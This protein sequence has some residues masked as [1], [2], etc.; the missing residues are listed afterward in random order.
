MQI[1]I[2]GGAAVDRGSRST[3]SSPTSAHAAD[4]IRAS[5]WLPQ[6]FGLDRLDDARGGR[7]GGPGHRA[8]HR[9]GPDLPA[10]PDDARGSRPARRPGALPTLG[11]SLG[12]GGDRDHV[13]WFAKPG[14][15]HP[16]VPL[17]PHAPAPG[18]GGRVRRRAAPCPPSRLARLEGSAVARVPSRR[19][20]P[21]D[22]RSSPAAGRRHR[23]VDDRP[24]DPR[25]RTRS[26]RSPR[27]AAEP[28]GAPRHVSSSRRCPSVSP[29]TSTEPAQARRSVCAVSGCSP[30]IRAMLD[31][32]GHEG[33]AAS[34]SS[35]TKRR[36]RGARRWWPTP[37]SPTSRPRRVRASMPTSRPQPRAPPVTR[38]RRAGRP[39]RRPAR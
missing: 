24:V 36:R 3:G 7:P 28:R 39:R 34:P 21:A 5:Y 30:A 26:R 23:H 6:I 18:R 33:S 32:E 4:R 10:P 12:H 37:A 9:G 22:A 8:R 16:R 17:D 38:L 14:A 35:V 29:T 13:G 1:G 15:P 27:R 31:A 20:V 2:F 19:S 11:L 25:R